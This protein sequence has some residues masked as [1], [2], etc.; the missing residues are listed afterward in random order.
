LE[1][2]AVLQPLGVIATRE[3]R[4]LCEATP[5]AAKNE[6]RLCSFYLREKRECGIWQF[7]PG[8]CSLYFCRANRKREEWSERVFAAES[9]FAH[10]ALAQLGFSPR[11]IL[12][13]VQR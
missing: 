10:M 3:F 8:E 6:K 7:R 2:R 9:N 1:G 12:E 13:Q 11:A 4:V 5:E